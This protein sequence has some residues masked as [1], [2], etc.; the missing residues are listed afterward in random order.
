MLSNKCFLYCNG[1]MDHLCPC[2]NGKMPEWMRRNGKFN[3]TVDALVK[4][5]KT[6]GIISLWSGLSPTLVLAIPATVVYFVS[7]EQLRLY[8]KRVQKKRH[9]CG[10]T[11]LDSCVSWWYG[12]DLGRII[13]ITEALKTVVKYSGISGLWMGLSTTLLRD[14]PFSAIYWLNYESIKRIFHTSQQTF[15]FNLAAGAVAGSIA[16]VFTIPFDVVKTHRQI[17]MGEKEIYSDKPIR[18]SN[19]WS[20][21]QRIYHQNGLRGLFTGLTPRLVK[22][23]PACAIMIATFE[24]GKR[25]FQSYNARKANEFEI[26]RN[27]HLLQHKP[28]STE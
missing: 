28:S 14:V 8:L 17:E 19:T 20:I 6:E 11:L 27:V 4:I 7:Y 3:G 10:T 26:E 25:F 2:A 13:E 23:A 9:Q 16:A 1:L 21:I 24:H 12:T 22:V 18:S 5:S 15:T